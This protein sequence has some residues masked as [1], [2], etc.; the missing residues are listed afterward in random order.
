MP[1]KDKAAKYRADQAWK[2]AHPEETK[3]HMRKHRYRISDA[4]YNRLCDD[5]EFTCEICRTID[6]VPG[7]GGRS[8][9]LNCDHDHTT[10]KVRGV[11]CQSCNLLLA[12]A[13][14]SIEVLVSA[15]HYLKAARG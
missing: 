9:S 12:H 11:L 4:D 8:K 2:R 7:S 14:E 10:G 1:R 6:E 3:A 5:A 13:K 15:I